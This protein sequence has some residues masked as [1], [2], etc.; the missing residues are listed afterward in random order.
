MA[1]V[2]AAGAAVAATAVFA[3]AACKD[4]GGPQQGPIRPAN[5]D[6]AFQQ[7]SPMRLAA[8]PGSRGA[9]VVTGASRGI[10]AAIAVVLAREG[11]VVAVN[12]TSSKSAAEDVVAEICSAGGVAAAF[13]ADVAN[14]ADVVQLFD[15]VQSMWPEQRLTALVNNAGVLAPKE[16]KELD[17]VDTAAYR[18]LFDIN[19]LGPLV[20]T[21]EFA[22]RATG[23]GGVVNISSGAAVNGKGPYGMSKAALN[24]MQAWLAPDLARRG[25]RMNSVS[26]GM[27]RSDMI[28]EWLAT[29]PDFKEIPMRRVGEPEEIAEVVAFLL[30]AK[31]SYVAGANVRVSGGRA[32][33]TFI[34]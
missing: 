26:P 22:R 21:R 19:V 7:Q 18:Q 27:T 10:G 15:E 2:T 3:P 9:A 33:G 29:D 8:P 30:S 17:S 28:A 6:E 32:P 34:H 12:Y 4:S 11:Y 14:E 16:C 24:S 23:M 31:A 25:I 20:T 1:V 13:R 5:C